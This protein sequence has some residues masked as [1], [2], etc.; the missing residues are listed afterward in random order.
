MFAAELLRVFADEK[1]RGQ[2]GTGFGGEV[3]ALFAAFVSGEAGLSKGNAAPVAE[4]GFSFATGAEA[5][6]G[7]EAALSARI[8]APNLSN[9]AHA[10]S[11]KAAVQAAPATAGP[12]I[13]LHAMPTQPEKVATLSAALAASGAPAAPAVETAAPAAHAAEAVQQSAAAPAAPA[14]SAASPASASSGAITA[15]ATNAAPSPAASTP[16]ASSAVAV[17]APKDAAGDAV[18]LGWVVSQLVKRGGAA[19][20]AALKIAATVDAAA[21][22]T[23]AVKSADAGSKAGDADTGALLKAGEKTALLS[24]EKTA[25]PEKTADAAH[26]VAKADGVADKIAA[27]LASALPDKGAS[28]L[29]GSAGKVAELVKLPDSVLL[30]AAADGTLAKLV[31]GRAET[32]QVVEGA[33]LKIEGFV[34]GEDALSFAPEIETRMLAHVHQEGRDFVIGDAATGT[35]RL[36]GIIPELPVAGHAA[37]ASVS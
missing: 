34:F 10:F 25:S 22:D 24:A 3:S 4:E 36:V 9:L 11:V 15:A 32:V 7:G 6:G 1:A 2:S 14:S 5:F 18:D 33:A 21:K 31:A 30:H 27:P 12:A 19:V 26:A 23:K 20:D 29:E 17:S 13:E 35:V 16:V 8:D 28:V 37:A